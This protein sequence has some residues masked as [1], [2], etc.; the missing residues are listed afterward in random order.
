MKSKKKRVIYII[1]IL[2]FITVATVLAIVIINNGVIYEVK[3]TE[4]QINSVLEEQFPVSEAYLNIMVIT[5]ESASAQLSEGSD[6]MLVSLNASVELKDNGT[7][8]SYTGTIDVSTGIGYN[9]ETGEI[10]LNDPV[11][12]SLRIDNFPEEHLEI[13]IAVVDSLVG[14]VLDGFPIYKLE[15][16]DIPTAITSIFLKDVKIADGYMVLT[17]GL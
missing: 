6:R 16:A 11:V 7:G 12:E 17:F 14:V 2:L 4:D 9:R 15:P 5:L 1:G 10:F 8:S 13:L 3:I